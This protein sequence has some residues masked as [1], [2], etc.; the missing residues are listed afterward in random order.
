MNCGMDIKII[1]L[2]CSR[3]AVCVSFS[4]P[5]FKVQTQYKQT[6]N[7]NLKSIVVSGGL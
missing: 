6:N 3:L 5:E 2:E 7:L 1:S 4:V